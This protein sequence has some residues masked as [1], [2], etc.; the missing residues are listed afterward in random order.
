MWLRIAPSAIETNAPLRTSTATPPPAAGKSIDLVLSY[1]H[2]FQE[3]LVV[4]PPPHKDRAQI[5]TDIAAGGT[6]QNM[7]KT[8]GALLDRAGAGQMVLEERKLDSPDGTARVPQVVTRQAANQPPT[9]INAGTYS[10]N[11]DVLAAGVNV[12]F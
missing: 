12:H 2:I 7:D 8:V 9:I 1:A 10:S 3:T 4:A 6:P 5:S 11:F